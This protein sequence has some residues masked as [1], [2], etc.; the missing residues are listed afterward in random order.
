MRVGRY[1]IASVVDVDLDEVTDL[2]GEVLCER[3]GREESDRCREDRGAQGGEH[4]P[5]VWSGRPPT[6]TPP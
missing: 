1:E 2:L 5:V 3:G 6:T 4:S